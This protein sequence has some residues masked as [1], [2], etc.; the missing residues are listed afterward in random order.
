MFT[1]LALLLSRSFLCG[2]LVERE[3]MLQKRHQWQ[4]DPSIP[5]LHRV[6]QYGELKYLM[7]FFS[8]LFCFSWRR[9]GR[10]FIFQTVTEIFRTSR[11]NV[12][13]NIM[14]IFITFFFFPAHTF[15]VIKKQLRENTCLPAAGEA[16]SGVQ[17]KI[18]CIK[19]QSVLLHQLFVFFCSFF[20]AKTRQ[21]GI[22]APTT[23]NNIR[24]QQKCNIITLINHQE[25][26]II[27]HAI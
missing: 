6:Q 25:I 16:C 14:N 19:P 3:I 20:R 11:K 21:R 12:Y 8:F 10:A 27:Q 2:I 26:T 15:S 18:F 13:L 24:Q 17:V 5:I 23:I 22:M 1:S 4:C 9:Q 7:L